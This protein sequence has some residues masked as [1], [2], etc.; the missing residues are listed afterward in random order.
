MM[1]APHAT[2]TAAHAIR[3][4][5]LPAELVAVRHGQSTANAAFA[6]AERTGALTVPIT[7][8]D[9]DL[10]LTLLGHAQAAAVS[11]RIAARPPHLVYCSPYRRTRET[12]SA[13]LGTLSDA[14][15]CVPEVRYDERLRD[16]DTGAWEM[17]T[18]AKLRRDQPAEMARRDHVGPFYFRPPG[19][20]NFPDVAL[21]VRSLL[22]DALPAAEGRRLLIVAHDAGVLMLRL[23]LDGLD[24]QAL[25]RVVDAGGVVGNCTVTRWVNDGA[26][27]SLA[28]YNNADHLRSLATAA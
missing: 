16:R 15:L 3:S 5:P 18:W 22:R 24:E 21:R 28:D 4:A 9:A 17:Q 26:G 2:E 8:R 27:L 11:R 13:I 20:E 19:G 23:I 6:E 10:P 25:L 12:L 1:T 14:G 7:D